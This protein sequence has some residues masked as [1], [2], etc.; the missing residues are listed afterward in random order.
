MLNLIKKIF[1]GKPAEVDAPYKMEAPTIQD[2]PVKG[3]VTKEA[4]QKAVKA[5]RNLQLKKLPLLNQKSLKL[6]RPK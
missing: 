2:A 4:V 1:G 5:A 3:T 6:L